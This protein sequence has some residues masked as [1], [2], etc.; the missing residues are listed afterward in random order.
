[1][2][3]TNPLD[4]LARDAEALRQFAPI[5]S[6][7][8][9]KA[10]PLASVEPEQVLTSPSRDQIQSEPSVSDV[11]QPPLHP[12]M[13]SLPGTTP[14][15]PNAR[16]INP[17]SPGRIRVSRKAATKKNPFQQL[18]KKYLWVGIVVM[19]I[20]LYISLAAYNK[21]V[22]EQG[23][24]DVAEQTA[25]AQKLNSMLGHDMA[26]TGQ[27]AAT[28]SPMASTTSPMSLALTAETLNPDFIE[29]HTT[30]GMAGQPNPANGETPAT[31]APPPMASADQYAEWA[32]GKLKGQNM[33][34]M[35]APAAPANVSPLPNQYTTGGSQP[36]FA[37]PPGTAAG[38]GE[39]PAAVP[40][41]VHRPRISEVIPGAKP[42]VNDPLAGR[43][44]V[45]SVPKV[46]A[47]YRAIRVVARADGMFAFVIPEEAE[48]LEAG[49]WMQAGDRL[50]TG[51]SI[52]KIRDD[53]ITL[54]SPDGQP[55]KVPVRYADLS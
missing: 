10:V 53:Q 4:R 49:N 52:L 12:A 23:R 21:R 9:P 46:V 45:A 40:A 34:I 18:P 6:P 39:F 2:A 48:A 19:V 14:I 36:E 32:M 33:P 24:Q 51:W 17:D 3:A 25:A 13:D 1:M 30:G 28:L 44:V 37:V 54:L 26:A 31:G 43:T 16:N 8:I 42:V 20:L 35:N 22:V 27:S 29:K 41:P 50:P 5:P 15:E 11:Q 7:E 38:N 47:P 55:V